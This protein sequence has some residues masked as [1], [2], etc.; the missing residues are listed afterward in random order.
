MG[1]VLV[2]LD[3]EWELSGIF[4]GGFSFVVF[5]C[6]YNGFVWVSKME[7]FI[8]SCFFMW[9]NKFLNDVDCGVD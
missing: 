4:V 8:V 7:E 3:F 9:G 6:F 2:R 1:I 5:N